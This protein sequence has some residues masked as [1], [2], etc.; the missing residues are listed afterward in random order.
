MAGQISGRSLGVA[1]ADR[2]TSWFYFSAASDNTADFIPTSKAGRRQARD[3]V[4]CWV[5]QHETSCDPETT[6]IED[7]DYGRK[8]IEESNLEIYR[9]IH[10][11]PNEA[12]N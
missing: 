5:T 2:N 11:E 12:E 8:I 1:E 9:R 7:F 4:M 3:V 10:D 6:A